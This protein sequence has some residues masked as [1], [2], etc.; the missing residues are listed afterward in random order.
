MLSVLSSNMKLADLLTALQA[1]NPASVKQYQEGALT[2]LLLHHQH[3]IRGLLLPQLTDLEKGGPDT[4]SHILVAVRCC[5]NSRE[6]GQLLPEL[7]LLLLPWTN[8]HTHNI[9]VFAQ[10]GMCA[11]QEVHPLDSWP[12]WQQGLRAGGVV[13]LRSL[14]H[15]YDTNADFCRF[16]R[17]MGSGM[18]SWSAASVVTPAGIFC[19]SLACG[20]GEVCLEDRIP[21]VC[22]TGCHL[23]W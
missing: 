7:A 11:L 6:P 10:L 3:L 1:T 15:F 8:H 5:I 12:A 4:A 2:Y 19:S 13:A 21:L 17:S 18:L 23:C 16:R 22:Q 9:R 20:A 14:Q